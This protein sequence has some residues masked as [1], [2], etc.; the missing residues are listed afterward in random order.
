MTR[1]DK[2]VVF[3]ASTI[4]APAALWLAVAVWQYGIEKPYGRSLLSIAKL[5]PADDYL[6]GVLAAGVGLGA[7]AATWLIQRFDS[8]FGGAAFKQF[9]RGTRIVSHRTLQH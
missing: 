7:V 8:R 4:T 6:M 1:D 3:V 5:T 2:T 9:L